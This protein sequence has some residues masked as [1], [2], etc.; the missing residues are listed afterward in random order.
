MTVFGVDHLAGRQRIRLS[1]LKY[2]NAVTQ[3]E[4]EDIVC[5]ACT[6]SMRGFETDRYRRSQ[7]V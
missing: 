2:S 4:L 7:R 1:D 3:Y 6:V 5:T